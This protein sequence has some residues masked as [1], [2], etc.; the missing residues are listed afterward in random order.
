M[1]SGKTP[2]DLR[3]LSPGKDHVSRTRPRS[4]YFLT[5]CHQVRKS[6]LNKR[7]ATDSDASGFAIDGIQQ[8]NREI[9]VY[10]LEGAPRASRLRKIQLCREIFSLIV[11]SVQ[12][13]RAQRLTFCC[14][15][16]LP[17]PSRVGP[18]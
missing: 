7:L 14:S 6:Q 2:Q 12:A 15:A 1:S 5:N 17:P 4:S 3:D 11:H 16:L 9:H 10:A 13:S 8:I 18:R